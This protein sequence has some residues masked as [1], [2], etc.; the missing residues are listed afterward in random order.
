[1]DVSEKI[2]IRS[3]FWDSN[4]RSS[5]PRSM[6]GSLIKY[7][8]LLNKCFANQ[9]KVK[10]YI[11]GSSKRLI[12][13]RLIVLNKCEIGG[14]FVHNK[15]PFI[16]CSPTIGLASVSLLCFA[17]HK[18]I[19]LFTLF[20]LYYIMRIIDSSIKEANPSLRHPF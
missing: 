14:S 20:I 12:K 16:K 15:L 6:G 10:Q 2:K 8:R 5:S 1:M 9:N 7:K 3:T 4:P 18:L 19:T 13:K 11:P 17:N